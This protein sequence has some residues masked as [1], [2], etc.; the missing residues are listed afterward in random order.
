M[1]SLTVI[2]ET[3]IVAVIRNATETNILPILEALNKGGV[4]AVEITAET[5]NVDRVIKRAAAQADWDM[6]IG[7]GTVLDPET[8]KSATMA[9]ANF[10]VSPSLNTETLKLTN[11]YGVLHIPGVLT[12]T[13]IVTAYEHGARMVKIFPAH[14]FGPDYVKAIRGPLLHVQAMATGGITLDNMNDYLEKGYTAVGTGSSLV[15][16][17]ALESET[18]YRKLAETAE[19]FTLKLQELN[20]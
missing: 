19:R 12:P 14:A 13:E 9:G 16:A 2:Q 20:D 6:C 5:P 7:A 17:K 4:K 8:A 18:D 3:R 1:D 11:R 15:N 10:I